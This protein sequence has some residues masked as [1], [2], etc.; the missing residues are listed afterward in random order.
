[1]SQFPLQDIAERLASSPDLEGALDAL[2][3]YL[4]AL[5]PT[6]HPSVALYDPQREA[7]VRVYQR[8]RGRLEHRDL[9]HPLDHMPARFV[10]KFVHPSAFFNGS[11][12]RSLLEK[13]FQSSPVY[14]PDRFEGPQLQ[15]LMAPIGWHSC[16][17]LPLNDRDELMGMIVVV[18][19]KTDVFTPAVTAALQ[20]LRSLAALAIARRLHATGRA[21]PESRAAEEAAR[22]TQVALQERLRE[23]HAEAERLAEESRAKTA[24]LEMAMLEA[25]QLRH[26]STGQRSELQAVTRQ[27]RALEEQTTGA[28]EHLNEGY[29][30]LADTQGQLRE[31]QRTVEMVRK[32]FDV[33]AVA[34]DSGSVTRSL[35]GWF[36]EQFQVERCSLMRLDEPQGDLRILAH[37]GLDPQVAG[38]VRVKVGSGVS[39][40]VASNRQSVFMRERTDESP[41]APTARDRYNSDS[42]ISVPLVHH[43]RVVGV[44]NLSNKRDGE[45][46][47]ELD[48]DRAQL[49][50]NVLAIALGGQ[51]RRAA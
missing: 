9:V 26:A 23:A 22:R 45:P 3:A 34:P 4:R 19:P 49:A 27:L 32:A 6:W 38:Q 20:P 18:S 37:R 1:V 41:V 5:Q 31:L 10:R 21:T 25:E 51:E 13:L 48:L 44:L 15:P 40:W 16:I 43:D 35:V 2:L 28:A 29:A 36:C 11:E 39:G 33:L 12:R 42:F 17:C 24:A 7:F 8:E 47:D 14:E 30:Q 50:G 46:F